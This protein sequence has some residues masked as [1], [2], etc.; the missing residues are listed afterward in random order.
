M[1]L[2]ALPRDR[3]IP[4]G[5]PPSN[6]VTRATSSDACAA[7]CQHYLNRNSAAKNI[8]VMVAND[9]VC[10]TA[11]QKYPHRDPRAKLHGKCY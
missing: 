6:M 2:S 11:S 9:V 8:L 7:A 4:V 10:A 5:S 1:M 3:S